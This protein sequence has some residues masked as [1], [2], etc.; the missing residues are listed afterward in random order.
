LTAVIAIR[1]DQPLGTIPERRPRK[2]RHTLAERFVSVNL[3]SDSFVP[4][5][6]EI[7]ISVTDD[8]EVRSCLPLADSN[9]VSESGFATLVRPGVGDAAAVRGEYR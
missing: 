6:P 4:V 7:A 2:T 1:I 8:E 5:A 3:Y 9:V